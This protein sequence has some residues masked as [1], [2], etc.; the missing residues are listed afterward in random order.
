MAAR[1]PPDASASDVAKAMFSAHAGGRLEEML[2]Y[3]HRDITWMP[4]ATRPGRTVYAGHADT[5]QLVKDQR[6]AMGSFRIE[7]EKF[8]ELDDGRLVCPGQTVTTTDIG[9]T[10]GLSFV[11]FLTFR[12]GLVYDLESEPRAGT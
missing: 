4:F 1:V 3:L 7:W 10:P 5:L 9:E 11:C 12:D 8:T 2:S 6:A